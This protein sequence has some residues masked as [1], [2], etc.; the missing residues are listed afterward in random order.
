MIGHWPELEKLKKMDEL[1]DAR[2]LLLQILSDYYKQSGADIIVVFDAMHVPGLTRSY[3]QYKLEVVW[4]A[5]GETADSYIESLTAQLQT[6]F[7]TVTVATSDQA[8]QWAIFSQG[9]I[10]I[11]A[12]EL[13][14]NIKRAQ[15]EVSQQAKQYQA[16]VTVRRSPWD[17]GQ[18]EKLTDLMNHLSD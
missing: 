15:K 10:R 6:Q 17:D 9:A 5:E 11:P 16:E 7:T 13:Y 2:D 8:E 3:Q 12:W 18:L 1:A 14:Q 4:T